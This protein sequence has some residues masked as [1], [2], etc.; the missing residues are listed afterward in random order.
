MFHRLMALIELAES[1]FAL[2]QIVICLDRSLREAEAAAFMKSLKWVGFD[3]VTLDMWAN[4]LD[5]TSNKWLFLGM[6]V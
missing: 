6:E 5:V 3:L 4:A 2:E 1:V